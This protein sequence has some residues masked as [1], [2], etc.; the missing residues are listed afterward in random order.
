TMY[1]QAADAKE[2]GHLG[3][4]SLEEMSE[5]VRNALKDLKEGDVSPPLHIGN[6]IQIFQVYKIIKPGQSAVAVATPEE[7]EKVRGTLVE[8][9]L[10][11]KYTEF[12]TNLRENA[13][14]SIKF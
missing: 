6:S 3:A 4:L 5:T 2:G 8:Q 13:M 9:K 14:I 10:N 11:Q 1:S 12:M 7:R